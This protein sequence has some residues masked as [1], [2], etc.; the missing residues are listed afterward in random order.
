MNLQHHIGTRP[1]Q[2]FIATFKRSATEIRGRE[3]SLLKHG[4]HRAV[5]HQ[6]P[7][8]EQLPQDFRGF[9]QIS[10]ALESG[11]LH[12]APQHRETSIK[13]GLPGRLHFT[14]VAC[15][16]RIPMRRSSAFFARMA[17]RRSRMGPYLMLRKNTERPVTI[18]QGTNLLVATD[19]AKI[20]A[21]ARDT[22]NGEGRPVASHPIPSGMAMLPNGSSKFS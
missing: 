12:R 6:D 19:P 13:G 11:I 8:R 14:Q 3:V 15:K 21:A 1:N 5:K 10:H 7:L 4:A 2:I 20:V 22:L 18:S 9:V 17:N 16:I